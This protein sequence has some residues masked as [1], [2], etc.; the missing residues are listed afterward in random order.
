MPDRSG[1]TVQ[2][3]GF[4]QIERSV[5]GLP[6]IGNHVLDEANIRPPLPLG[7]IA[8]AGEAQ[9]PTVGPSLGSET[10]VVAMFLKLCNEVTQATPTGFTKG[11]DNGFIGDGHPWLIHQVGDPS[12]QHK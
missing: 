12:Q 2:A 10:R 5:K 6:D 7:A 9:L 1:A 8:T 4:G 11:C 3:A